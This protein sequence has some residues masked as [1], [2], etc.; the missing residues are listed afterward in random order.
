MRYEKRTNSDGSTYYSFVYYDNKKKTQTRLSR[1]EIRNRFG[2]DILTEDEA[3]ECLKLLE[4]KHQSEKMRIEKRISW[5]KE[6]YNFAKMLDDYTEKQ[7]KTAP[8]SWENNQFYLKH[9]VLY[10]FLQVK[11]LNNIELWTDNY[12]GFQT[13]LEKSAKTIRSG[14]PIAV[15]SRNHAIKSLNTFMEQ[16]YNEGIISTYKKCGTFPEH[17][18]NSRS[19]DDVIY[20]E[21]MELIFKE[22]KNLGYKEEAIYFRYLYF[23]GMRFNEGLCISLG[24]LFQGEIDSGFMKKKLDAYNIKY[25]GYIVSDGQFGGIDKHG[26][27]IRL[28]FKGKRKIDEKFNRIIPITDKVLWNSLVDIASEKFEEAGANKRDCLLFPTIDD[29]TATNRLKEAFDKLKLHW[30]P[31]HCLRHSRATWLIGETGDPMLARLWL[32][33]TSPRTIERYNHIYQQV[34]RQ[35]KAEKLTGKTFGLKKV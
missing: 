31:W 29:T 12:S 7:K 23:S 5:E 27:V 21:E 22:L 32:G 24:D 3:K 28:P 15:A 25:F 19:I 33:H 30:R 18:L 14:K 4:A 26:S 17:L 16:L 35:A 6:F 13:W 20:P 34:V 10:Y 9:Y 1:K 8:N 11:R 2:K